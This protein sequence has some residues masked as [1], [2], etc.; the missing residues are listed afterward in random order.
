[1]TDDR[2]TDNRTEIE[3]TTDTTGTPDHDVVIVGG[4]PA[5]CSAGVF[6]A[7]YGLD[8]LVFDR[9]RSSIQRCAHLENYPGFPAGI[10]IGT[11][12]DLLHAHA[13]EAGCE[14]VPDMVESVERVDEGFVVEP[15]EG[16]RVTTVRVLAATRYGGEYLRPLDGGEDGGLFE[17][18]DHDGE[19]H[20]HFDR[21]YA[22]PDGTTPIDGLYVASP[23]AAADRQAIVAAGR[24]ARVGLTILDEIRREHGHPE[25]LVDHY[26]WVRNKTELTGKWADREHWR[27]YADTHRP[28]DHDMNDERWATLRERE[29]DRRFAQYIGPDEIEE[30]ETAG[31]RALL[32]HLDD[33]LILERAREITAEGNSL[34]ER[35]I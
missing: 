23:S 14:V 28:D 34:E 17:S 25:G 15:Q 27:E 18:H 21:S 30:R 24:G 19:V 35:V 11:F 2:S 16:A 20:E 32:E 10:D 3:R 8:T 13:E 29:I 7:R 33:A 9:G 6:C 5:G 4:G 31:Q 22:K 1:M 12:Y 26:D